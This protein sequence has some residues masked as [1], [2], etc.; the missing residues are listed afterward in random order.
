[1]S[2]FIVF[3]ATF[4]ISSRLDLFYENITGVSLMPQYHTITIIYI[5][6]CAFFFSYKTN[7]VYKNLSIPQYEYFKISIFLTCIIMS[8]G[9]FF[10]YSI[11]QNDLF[12]IL[13][14][15]CSMFGCISF[16]IHLFI[17][18]RFLSLYRPDIY[19]KIHWFYDIALQFLVILLLVFTRVNGYIEIFYSFIVCMYLYCIEKNL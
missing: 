15:A 17:Y 13:H 8:I 2:Y 19:L 5:V 16:L 18:T 7:L 11:N 3:I 1:M 9:A 12:S 10:P 6:F 14:V 4:I